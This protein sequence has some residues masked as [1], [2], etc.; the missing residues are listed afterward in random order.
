MIQVSVKSPKSGNAVSFN[1]D[2]GKDLQEAVAK[3]GEARV[4]GFFAAHCS[5]DA[6]NKARA[7]L[8]AGQS[9]EAVA[10]ALAVYE[11]GLKIATKGAAVTVEQMAAA[12]LRM[13]ADQKA[14]YLAD[15][16]AK[17]K[18]AEQGA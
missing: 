8:N 14:K 7:L 16:S 9:P 18:A 4:Y 13:P 10:S 6:G 11:P 5:T 2:I 12:I 17:L 15:L 1:I 3:Y